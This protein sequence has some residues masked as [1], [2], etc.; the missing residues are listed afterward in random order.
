MYYGG[1]TGFSLPSCGVDADFSDEWQQTRLEPSSYLCNGTSWPRLVTSFSLVNFVC[2]LLNASR[3]PTFGSLPF[4]VS[5]TTSNAIPFGIELGCDEISRKCFFL[6]SGPRLRERE[7]ERE[8]R[9]AH[10]RCF[11]FSL[12]GFD[13][14]ATLSPGAVARQTTSLAHTSVVCPALDFYGNARQHWP[15]HRRLGQIPVHLTSSRVRNDP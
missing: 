7:R 9:T 12:R 8:N 4:F 11:G 15:W 3:G 13:G 14:S 6:A 2:P 1:F 10:F 5:L